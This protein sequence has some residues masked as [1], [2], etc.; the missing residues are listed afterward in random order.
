MGQHF[1]TPAHAGIRQRDD[2]GAAAGFTF[3]PSCQSVTPL[4]NSSRIMRSF[5]VVQPRTV[6]AMGRLNHVA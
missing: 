3:I 1:I 4:K 2:Y 5:P 6:G